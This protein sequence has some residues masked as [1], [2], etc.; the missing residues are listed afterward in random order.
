M[1]LRNLLKGCFKNRISI[2]SSELNIECLFLSKPSR[3]NL[4]D[5]HLSTAFL[6][7][8]VYK[9]EPEFPDFFLHFAMLPNRRVK[10]GPD[11]TKVL[12]KVLKTKEKSKS[13]LDGQFELRLN[14]GTWGKDLIVPISRTRRRHIRFVWSRHDYFGCTTSSQN[15]N[16]GLTKLA[17]SVAEAYQKMYYYR[18]KRVKR[19]KARLSPNI[20]RRPSSSKTRAA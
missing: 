13:K 15:T 7:R 19:S 9:M 8:F 16:I 18:Y 14:L 4:I 3:Q 17:L 11:D 5:R 1:F 20:G 12:T 6:K 2:Y 10:T